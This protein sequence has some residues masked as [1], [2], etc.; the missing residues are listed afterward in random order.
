M[1]EKEKQRNERERETE[2]ERMKDRRKSLTDQKG[3]N[4]LILFS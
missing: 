2:N 4:C 1:K 3:K